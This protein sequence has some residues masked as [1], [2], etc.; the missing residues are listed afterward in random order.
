MGKVEIERRELP[1]YKAREGDIEI[2]EKS[3]SGKY[4][5]II[6]VMLHTF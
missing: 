1:R 4:Q 6:I 3:I 2:E 5:K